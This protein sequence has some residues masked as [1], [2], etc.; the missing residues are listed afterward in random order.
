MSRLETSTLQ[1]NDAI[2]GDLNAGVVLD[3]VGLSIYNAD[4]AKDIVILTKRGTTITYTAV[5]AGTQ[6][7][8]PMF[9]AITSATTSTDMVVAILTQP[10]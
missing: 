5:P 2:D 6:I 10:F 9:T 1:A 3:G 4:D 7:L 8:T